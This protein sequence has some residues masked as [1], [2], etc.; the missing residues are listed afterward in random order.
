VDFENAIDRVIAG[1]ERKSRVINPREKRIVAVHEAGHA[2]VAELRPTA[3]RVAR[4]SI[5]PRGMAALG[6]TRQQPTE[7]RYVLTR[8][9]LLERLDVML[10]GRVAE[11]IALGDVSTGAH[12]DLQRATDLARDMVTRFG[13][14]EAVGL[15]THERARQAAY[16]DVPAPARMAFSEA[17]AEAI[18]SA[19]RRLLDDA[20]GRAYATLSEHRPAL[21]SLASLLMEREVVDR[22]MLVQLLA[23][24][25]AH[26][27]A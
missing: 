17:T 11:E 1:L 6:Y 15:A 22:A 27:A 2:L 23:P 21:D 25:P 14:T 20:R 10:G 4:I 16:L 19:V 18:D 9:E 13:M 8:T 5:I 12:D 24:V 7:D 3:D 26:A